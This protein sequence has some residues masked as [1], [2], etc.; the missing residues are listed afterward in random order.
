MKVKIA[1]IDSGIMPD[2]GFFNGSAIGQYGYH[3]DDTGKIAESNGNSVENKHGT[4]V[5]LIIRHICWHIDIESYN[6]LNSQC[7]GDGRILIYA[8][9]KAIQ[10]HPHIIHLSLGTTRWRYFAK[11]QWLVFKARRKGI[12]IVTS[13]HKSGRSAYPAN[14]TG[15]IRVKL[16]RDI[17]NRQYVFEKGYFFATDKTQDIKGI[18]ELGI[19]RLFGTSAASAFITGHLASLIQ[20]KRNLNQFQIMK[21]LKTNSLKYGVQNAIKSE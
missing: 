10:R 7:K 9:E 12:H 19:I 3:F 11:L 18:K 14:C 15:T 6:I 1:I 13:T 16:N 17:P 4:G 21:L 5:A 8:F 20:S 2:T